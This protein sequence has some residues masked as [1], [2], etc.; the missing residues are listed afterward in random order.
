MRTNKRIPALLGATVGLALLGILAAP[1]TL[2]AQTFPTK[3]IRFIVTVLP[4]GGAD[5]LARTFGGK[6]PTK[7]GGIWPES[8]VS[9]S[10]P[11]LSICSHEVSLL[12][13]SLSCAMRAA[14]RARLPTVGR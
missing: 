13:E 1:G 6:L 14:G 4:G 12:M 9:S 3:N 7:T 11:I 10:W 2:L 5:I 8:R